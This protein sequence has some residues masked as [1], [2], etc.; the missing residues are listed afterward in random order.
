VQVNNQTITIREGDILLIEPGE[1]YTILTNSPSYYHL[2]IQMP[3]E[4]E[5]KIAAERELVERIITGL[6]YLTIVIDW[7]T[8]Q[9]SL[10]QWT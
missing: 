7:L 10:V 4:F 9:F 6:L 8:F 2:V 1:A 3:G 5:A